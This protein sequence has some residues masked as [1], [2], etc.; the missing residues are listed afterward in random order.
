M[1][2]S[3]D[4]GHPLGIRAHRPRR[5]CRLFRGTRYSVARQASASSQTRR[6]SC[7]RQ[8]DI[9]I[10]SW[11]GKKFRPGAGK[12]REGWLDIPAVRSGSLYEI[13]SADILQPGPAALTDGLRQLRDIV[14]RWAQT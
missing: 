11:C 6:T 5:R 7:V 2:R 4:L 8:P 14:Q 12:Q 3:V 9:I 1:E 13:K 10:G